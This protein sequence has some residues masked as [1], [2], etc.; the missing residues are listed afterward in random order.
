MSLRMQQGRETL[1]CSGAGAVEHQQL[2]EGLPQV[3]WLIKSLF[4][5]ILNLK[6]REF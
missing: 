5:K 3:E 1:P 4:F 6:L 2:L